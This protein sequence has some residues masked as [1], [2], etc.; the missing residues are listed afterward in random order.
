MTADAGT[1]PNANANADTTTSTST[2]A[3]PR[4]NPAT[5]GRR[6]DSNAVE[7]TNGRRVY[8]RAFIYVGAVHLFAALLFVMFAL[9][10]RR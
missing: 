1:E 2:D 3:Y 5:P 7:K 9:G 6:A 8:W 4:R 10:D